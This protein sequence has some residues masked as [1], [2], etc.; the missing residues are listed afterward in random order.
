MSQLTGSCWNKET[1]IAPC[2]LLEKHLA[3]WQPV[4]MQLSAGQPKRVQTLPEDV[5]LGD[6]P[7]SPPAS[8]LPC[9]TPSVR[10][11][12]PTVMLGCGL[13]HSR[14]ETC[15]RHSRGFSPESAVKH[16]P[17]APGCLHLVSVFAKGPPGFRVSA[18]EAHRTG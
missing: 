8:H 18:A 6:A 2:W 1:A 10:V 11:P 14:S 7:I 5:A 16:S 15:E 13:E 9:L 17:A 12:D 4:V 3:A